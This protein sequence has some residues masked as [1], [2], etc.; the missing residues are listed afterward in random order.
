MSFLLISASSEVLAKE[1]PDTTVETAKTGGKKVKPKADQPIT[2][3]TMEVTEKSDQKLAVASA[4]VAA[5]LGGVSLV[6]INELHDRN[7]SSVAD[8]FRYVP[9]VWATSQSGNDEVFISSRGSNLDANNFAGSGVKILQD[10]MP[11][12]AADGNNHNRMIDPLASSFATVAR[13][14]NAFKY[15]A[16]TLGGAIDFTSP[17]AHNS[18]AMRLSLSGGSFGQFLG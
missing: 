4:E 2:L 13:G 18:P 7:V 16:S 3:K 6:N 5:S 1:L 12:T 8:F 17:T 10:G 15:G 11:V 14:G 9:G